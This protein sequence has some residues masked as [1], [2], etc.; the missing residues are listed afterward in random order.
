ML[1][2]RPSFSLPLL[3]ATTVLGL[4]LAGCG[5]DDS[6]PAESAGDGQSSRQAAVQQVEAACTELAGH[7]VWL[8]A[9]MA[10]EDLSSA[11]AA[12]VIRRAEE[13]FR[14]TLTAIDPPDELRGPIGRLAEPAD[15]SRSSSAEADAALD[16]TLGL[17]REIGAETCAKQVEASKL[18]LGGSGVE[19][20]YEQ[21]GATLPKRPTDW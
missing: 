19:Q 17:Y 21:V 6:G 9:H 5:D 4:G 12:A 18:V 7:T 2:R 3:V 11:D 1:A 8:P 10:D 14:S 15:A 13:T 16:R 20:A